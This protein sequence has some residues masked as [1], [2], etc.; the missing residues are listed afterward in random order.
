MWFFFSASEP[1]HDVFVVK[2]SFKGLR[3]KSDL[4]LF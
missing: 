2:K 4:I 1:Q 3:S